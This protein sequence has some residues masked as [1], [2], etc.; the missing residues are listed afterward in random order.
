MEL[1]L[2]ASVVI[3]WYLDEKLTQKALEY[4]QKHLDGKITL[5]A[6]S[7]LPYELVNALSTKTGINLEAVQEAIAAFYFTGIKQFPLTK[8]LAQKTADL[9]KKF[10]IPAYDAAYIALAQSL[11][12]NL[13]T[14]DKKL[15]QKT[16]LIRLVKMLKKN[17]KPIA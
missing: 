15:Y 13:F 14:A 6:P 1:V 9:S 10:K 7:L 3:K 17:Q 8:N 4:R 16:K 5:A 12:C 11:K 2:D